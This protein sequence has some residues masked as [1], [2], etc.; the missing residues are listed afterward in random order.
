MLR[1]RVILKEGSIATIGNIDTLYI[2]SDNDNSI[3]TINEANGIRVL[4][5]KEGGDVRISDRKLKETE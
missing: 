3:E 2:E 4:E 1:I 5:V